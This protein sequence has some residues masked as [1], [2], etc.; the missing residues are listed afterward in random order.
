MLFIITIGETKLSIV[1][2]KS[3]KMRGKAC[4]G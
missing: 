1:L 4:Q 2:I 3:V